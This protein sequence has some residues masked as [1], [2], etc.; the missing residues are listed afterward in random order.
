MPSE[1]FEKLRR[2]KIDWKPLDIHDFPLTVTSQSPL[3][4]LS[5]KM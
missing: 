3:E 2:V 1:Y 4:N 5:K